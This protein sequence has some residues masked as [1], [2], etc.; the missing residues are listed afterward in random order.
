MS[1]R[2]FED[3]EVE[4]L[5]FFGE[6]AKLSA[7]VRASLVCRVVDFSGSEGHEVRYGSRSD[8]EGGSC[9]VGT[10]WALAL[11][12]AFAVAVCGIWNLFRFLR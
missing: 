2:A 5:M 3:V 10:A 6:A 7:P 1:S 9:L 4:E 11:E 12:A 8:P